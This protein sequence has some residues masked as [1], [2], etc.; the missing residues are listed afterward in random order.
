MSALFFLVAHFRVLLPLPS[1][2]GHHIRLLE[3]GRLHEVPQ[4]ID[5]AHRR[6]DV[7]GIAIEEEVERTMSTFRVML[8]HDHARHHRKG[9]VDHTVFQDLHREHLLAE[10]VHQPEVH[11]E[12]EEEVQ[13]TALT[14]ATAGAGAGRGVSREVEG[15]MGKGELLGRE[16]FSKHCI[17]I[18]ST[19]KLA[20]RENGI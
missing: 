12:G 3:Q 1:Q 10:E 5:I 2:G 17:N 11:R 16:L 20:I 18:L 8:I 14:V 19:S 7:V 13:A 6:L 9:G 4:A 15:G